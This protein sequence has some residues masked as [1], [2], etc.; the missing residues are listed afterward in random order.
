MER[1]TIQ[2]KEFIRV[3]FNRDW[4]ILDFG[5]IE[6]NSRCLG[7]YP[8][9]LANAFNRNWCIFVDRWKPNSGTF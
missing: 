9:F 8:D 2:T 3:I 1:H 4:R 7:R 5:K 6:F